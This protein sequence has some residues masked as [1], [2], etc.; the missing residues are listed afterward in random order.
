MGDEVHVLAPYHPAVIPFP[1]PVTVHHFRYIWHDR[2]AIMGY[3]EA[4]KSD[5]VLRPL[6]YALAPLFAMAE[7]WALKR[8]LRQYQFDVVHGHWVVPNG[9]VA[10]HAVRAA[11]VPLVITLH[12][13][14]IF[15]AKQ[16]PILRKVARWT[17]AQSEAV[18]ACSPELIRGAEEIGE[19]AENLHLVPWAMDVKAFAETAKS[20]E[21]R[22]EWNLQPEQPVIMTVGR[23]VE[24]KGTDYLLRAMPR[25]LAACPSAH[26]MIVGDG[27]EIPRLQELT[28]GLGIQKSVTFVGRILWNEVAIYMQLCNIFVVPSV[29]DAQGNVDGLP[30]T[31][32]E[33]MSA[34]K[35]V[36]A[37]RVAGIPLAVVDQ[38]TGILV[39]EKDEIQLANAITAL[40]G[41]P[42]IGAAY[43]AQGRARIETHFNWQSV[44]Q[45]YRDFYRQAVD[46]GNRGRK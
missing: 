27:P 30:S 41:A 5:R 23:M 46:A 2:F 17:L 34:G 45:K 22:Q 44:G 7:Y 20:A 36:V 39:D 15:L 43:G 6:A 13:S 18:T 28:A 14:D 38:E 37:S 8:L 9:F 1:S 25:I 42:A 40:I 29:H 16:Q 4:M 10:A 3:A 33:A 11:R 12:G 32:L 21:L 24:K 31:V 26:C 35:P 19:T